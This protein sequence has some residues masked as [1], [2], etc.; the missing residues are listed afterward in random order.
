MKHLISRTVLTTASSGVGNVI[1]G[2]KVQTGKASSKAATAGKT[3]RTGKTATTAG[4]GAAQ[5]L[6]DRWTTAIETRTAAVKAAGFTTACREA[7]IW[8]HCRLA[9]KTHPREFFA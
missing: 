3:A 5:P 1:L 9:P 7:I 2:I 6:S 8:S 4:S